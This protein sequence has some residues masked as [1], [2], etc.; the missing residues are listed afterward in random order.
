[1]VVLVNGAFAVVQEHRADRAADRLRDLLP[2]R[3]TVRRGGRP[4]TVPA[5]DLVPGDRVVL[6]AGDR[7]SADLAVASG[8]GL[9]VDESTLTG[10]SVPRQAEAGDQLYAG[11]FVVEGAAEADVVATGEGTRLAGI[12]ALTGQVRRPPSPL[13]VRLNRMAGIVAAV[14]V[15]VGTAFFGLAILL[16]TSPVPAFLLALGVTVALIPEGLLPTVTLALAWGSRRMADSNALVRR[17]EAVETLGSVTFICTDK[18][19]TLTRNEMAAVEVWTPAGEAEIRG[20]GHEPHGQVV[21]SPPAAVATAD[22]AYAAVRASAGR[23]VSH[24]GRLEPHGD[25]MEV[26]L[27][28]LALRAGVDIIGR[29][30]AVPTSHRYP[31]DRQRLRYG[32]V[33]ADTLYI[34]GA[35]EAVLSACVGDQAEARAAAAAHDMAE[36]G[37]R[38]L[39][40]ATRTGTDLGHGP[41]ADERDLTL[42]GV[43][44]LLDPPRPD[45]AEAVA[46]CRAAGIRLALITGDHAGTARAVS[47]QVSLLG[48]EPLVINAADLP[49]DE[50]ALGD[51]IDHDGAVVA[52]VTPEDK[53]R[54]TRALQQRGHAVAMTGDG[55]NDAPALRKAD[56]GVAMGATGSDVARETADLVLLDDHLATI[57]TAVRLGRA[58]FANIRRFL[59][60]HLSDNVAELAPFLLWGLTGG[61]FPLALGVLQILAL[62]IGTDL[63]PALALGAEPPS[64]RALKGTAR[65]GGLIDRRVMRRAF[66]VL[67][68]TEVLISMSAFTIVLLAGGWRW[69]TEPDP[70]LLATASGTAFTAIVL[71]QLANAFACRSETR[72]G[73]RLDPRTN[74]LL[75]GAIAVEILLLL[76]FLSIPPL[77][78]LL[79]GTMPT[80]LGWALAALAVP[81]VLLTDAADKTWRTRTRD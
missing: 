14:A 61:T 20:E 22:L 80:T 40:V 58:T 30:Q 62:D 64:P 19:G 77:P 15:T 7:I 36:R 2:V 18:T 37:L 59:T 5:A 57:I 47:K 49:T 71:G 10:E 76:V 51:L 4:Y 9:A 33:A 23:L 54:I 55:V 75:P 3:A 29:E 45:A 81:A 11:T 66:G 43:V 24:D 56:I 12:A 70:Q 72:P 42:L 46:A 6:E 53:L 34:K 52:R 35:P 63:L 65:T 50:A 74:P 69:G 13:A 26:A 38:V 21:A 39:A 16:G 48:A 31:F 79:G 32:A 73:Y 17:L 44:G 68:P 67:G 25:P 60:Y 41:Q 78:D 28:V 1:V 27:Y 8:S